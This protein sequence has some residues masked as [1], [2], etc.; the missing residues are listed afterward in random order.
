MLDL[1]DIQRIYFLGIGGIGMSGLAH[2]FLNLGY[3]V[4]GFDRTSTAITRELESRGATIIY[5]DEVELYP[6]EEQMVIY[7]PAIPKTNVGYNYFRRRGFLMYKR[8]QIL[9]LIADNY[10]V[11]AV[12]GTHGKTTTSTI[13]AHILH[14]SSKGCIA[15]LGGVSANYNTNFIMDE[16]P[17]MAVVEADE[18]DRSFLSL[19][20]HTAIITNMDADHLDIYGNK[21]ALEVSFNMFALQT[22]KKG[23]I[24]LKKGLALKEEPFA[25][26]Y[27]YGLTKD[28]DFYADDIEIE[29]GSYHFTLVT[30]EEKLEDLVFPYP[31]RHNLENAVAASAAAWLNG[32]SNQQNKKGLATF[33]GVNRRF[34]S[35]LK[36]KKIVFVDDYAHHPTELDACFSALR[37]LYPLKKITAVFQPH[38][39]SR[40]RDFMAQFAASLSKVDAIVLL[41]I[42]PARE[43]PMEGITSS[44]LLEQITLKDKALV[45]FDAL[46]QYIETLETEVLVTVGAGDISNLVQPLKEMLIKKY[47]IKA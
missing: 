23:N 10:K 21:D 32:V 36:E 8:S 27:S 13:L 47:S 35:I 33:K 7:T 9:G 14:Q 11:L 39:F 3:H 6:K 45:P 38:L 46:V 37:E 16:A 28:A 43:L 5:K 19:Y 34:E 41:D 25:K 31:G 24:L 20:P 15:F 29:D 18:F 42:Y 26:V 44:V 17:A 30:P 12:A 22:K 4:S 40:T 2:Y 1:R